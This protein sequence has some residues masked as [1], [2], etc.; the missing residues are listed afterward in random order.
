MD[1]A[2]VAVSVPAQPESAGVRRVV[3]RPGSEL[4]AHR[5][6]GRVWVR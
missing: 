3:G 2:L 5:A 4:A 1:Q 6:L